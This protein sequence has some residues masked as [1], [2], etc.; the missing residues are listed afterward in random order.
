MTIFCVFWYTYMKTLTKTTKFITT[1]TTTNEFTALGL[2][3]YPFILPSIL[4]IEP[5]DL[6]ELTSDDMEFVQEFAEKI[7]S[8]PLENMIGFRDL[9]VP[10]EIPKHVM[11]LS[12]MPIYETIKSIVPKDK[13]SSHPHILAM[14]RSLQFYEK[15]GVAYACFREI[16]NRIYH[17]TEF[18]DDFPHQ[19]AQAVL[20]SFKETEESQFSAFKVMKE[21]FNDINIDDKNDPPII[22]E[23]QSTG[24]K[25]PMKI[26][27]LN[28]RAIKPT[29]YRKPPSQNAFK[30]ARKNPKTKVIERSRSSLNDVIL[31]YEPQMNLLNLPLRLSIDGDTLDTID[32]L[33]DALKTPI[34]VTHGV[35]ENFSDLLTR[36][37]SIFENSNIKVDVDIPQIKNNVQHF[38]ILSAIGAAGLAHYNNPTKTTLVVFLGLL[39]AGILKEGLL[40]IPGM[41]ELTAFIGRYIM[42]YESIVP[43]MSS[44]T[45]SNIVSSLTMMLIALATGTSKTPWSKEIITH[46]FSFKKNF[47][48]VEGCLKAVISVIEMIATYITRDLFGGDSVVIVESSRADINDFLSKMRNIADKLHLNKFSFNPENAKLV[49]DLWLEGQDIISKIPRSSDPGLINSMNTAVAWLFSVKKQFDGMNLSFNGARVEPVSYLFLGP[50]GTGKSQLL[51]PLSYEILSRVLPEHKIP[52]FKANPNTFIFNRQAECVYWDGYNTDKWICFIDDLGQ[53]RDVAGQPD[54]EW[55]NWIRMVSTFNYVLHMASLEKK[56]NVYFQSRFVIGNSNLKS[57]NVESI[58]ELEAFERRVDKCYICVPKPE[59]CLQ[60]DTGH[61]WGKRLD[62]SKLPIGPLGVTEMQPET[63]EFH[64][65]FTMGPQ[66]GQPTGVVLDFSSIALEMVELSEIKQKRFDQMQLRLNSILERNALKPQGALFNPRSSSSPRKTTEKVAEKFISRCKNNP[67]C[68]DIFAYLLGKSQLL[69]GYPCDLIETVSRFYKLYGSP[70]DQVPDFTMEDLSAFIH[71]EDPRFEMLIEPEEAA[72]PIEEP[73]CI[74]KCIENLSKYCDRILDMFGKTSHWFLRM[75]KVITQKF[76][77]LLI[78]IIP[79]LGALTISGAAAYLYNRMHG[80][81]MAFSPQLYSG[82][83]Q[84][85]RNSRPKVKSVNLKSIRNRYNYNSSSGIAKQSLGKYDSA[86]YDI[87]QKIIRRN[88]YE[89]WLP[90]QDT[91][92]G[93]VTFIRGRVIAMPKHFATEVYEVLEQYPE[94]DKELVTF[95]KSGKSDVVFQVELIELLNVISGTDLESLDMVFVKLPGHVMNHC[96]ITK[97]FMPLDQ[98]SKRR[99]FAFRLVLPCVDV[100]E[101]WMGTAEPICSAVVGTE[102]SYIVS[103]GFRYNAYTKPGDCGALFTILD[104]HSGQ[105]KILGFHV[106][107]AQEMGFGISNCVD[108]ETVLESLK[109]T[110]EIIEHYEDDLKPQSNAVILDGRFNELYEHELTQTSGGKS[111][112]IRSPLYG[113]WK[114]AL[115]KPAKLAPF[116]NSDGNR[117]NPYDLAVSKYCTPYVHIPEKTVKI[118]GDMIFQHLNAVSTKCTLKRTLTFEEAILGVEGCP[119]F[120]SIS[121]ATSCGFPDTALPGT[122]SKGKEK[123]FGKDQIYDL[124]NKEAM[125]LRADCENIIIQARRGIR[126]EHI[127]ADC[128]KDER[129]PLEKVDLGKTRLFSA[130]PIRL[131]IVFRMY[132]GAFITW[133]QENRIYNGFAVG[134]NPYSTEWHLL[135]NELLK[136]GTTDSS[137]IGAGDFSGYDGREKVPIMNDILR[138]INEWYGDEDSRIREVLWL[139]IVNSKHIFGRLVYAWSSSN[140]SGCPVTTPLNNLYNHYVAA[141][142]WFKKN[143]FSI[144]KL[145]EFYDCVTYISFG[146]DNIFSVRLDCLELFNEKAM[147]ELAPDLGQLYTSETKTAVSNYMRKITEVTFLKRSFRFEKVYDRFCAPLDLDVVLEIPYWTKDCDIRMSIVDDNVNLSLQELSLHD[148]EVFEKFAPKIIEAYEKRCRKCPKL[149]KR[150]SLLKVTEG[151]DNFY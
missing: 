80:I 70:F 76:D 71:D 90:D 31:S 10:G 16:E 125:Q 78:Y 22:Y 114:P 128:L 35:D 121:R 20:S 133:C 102:E 92:L 77:H 79:I 146:D 111:K 69:Y 62:K 28:Q 118:I 135:A 130:C 49:H 144:V 68:V 106:A 40:I 117:I 36:L 37:T 131:L 108:L 63:S 33:K 7:R 13:W 23:F 66:K 38:F 110:T 26:K 139:E 72:T 87:I 94:Y 134:V 44:S 85:D 65:V 74:K 98:I 145:Y 15:P 109:E 112:I 61:L 4:R 50:P 6:S 147:E 138:G 3:G 58:V 132:F 123:Y 150:F 116:T 127:F 11:L 113:A 47:E 142:V 27:P 42:E 140:P 56:G 75:F 81:V 52:E 48:S 24:F 100:H 136:F 12:T 96:D 73:S 122:K 105:R 57:F 67:I 32:G 64:E 83:D 126:L 101:S 99:D 18:S 141:Y 45:F 43:Q 55:M 120:G 17:L 60:P 19:V 14:E 143:N 30:M 91:R 59:F 41:A 54:N 88:C 5:F 34:H 119:E 46:M 1:M 82:K 97:Y 86:N 151:R 8:Q 103:K 53:L 95:K 107:G 51:Y 137:N 9:F 25:S 148:P 89:I 115:T 129:R 2:N 29:S 93:F 104:T 124:S 149:T 21:H 39:T 84:R